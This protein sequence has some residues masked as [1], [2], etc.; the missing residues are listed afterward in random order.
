MGTASPL[1][2]SLSV[3]SEIFLRFSSFFLEGEGEGNLGGWRDGLK[4][5][6]VF[7]GLFP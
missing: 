7:G 2:P 3:S 4:Q 6:G 1:S 5:I